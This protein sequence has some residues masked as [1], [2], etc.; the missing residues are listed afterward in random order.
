[1]IKSNECCKCKSKNVKKVFTD[2]GIRHY[3]CLKCAKK[4]PIRKDPEKEKVKRHNPIKGYKKIMDK[5]F[6][7][8]TMLINMELRNG[9]HDLFMI[10][11]NKSSFKYAGGCYIIDPEAKYFMLGSKCYCMDFHQDMTIPVKRKIDA[12]ALNEKLKD[13]INDTNVD[14]DIETS[15]NPYSL[16]EFMVSNV[17]Q[18]SLRGEQIDRFLKSIKIMMFVTMIVCIG[19]F[20]IFVFK[21]GILKSIKIL[22]L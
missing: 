5:L 6:P 8:K 16:Q 10:S 17:I 7:A 1:M 13:A 19:H 12:Q 18:K 14:F 20:L 4:Y 11:E 21:S 9:M 2:R 3:Y 22:G 15:L